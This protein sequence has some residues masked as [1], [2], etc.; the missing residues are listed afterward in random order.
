MLP[1]G[2]DGECGC[3]PP[4]IPTAKATSFPE[5]IALLRQYAEIERLKAENEA[6]RKRGKFAIGDQVHKIGGAV[7]SGRI[8][9]IYSTALTPEGYCVESDAHPGSVQIYPVA[10]LA[11]RL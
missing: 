11:A 2:D 10:A 5:E 4:P 8:V 6:L 9:G 7:W 1:F 3:S